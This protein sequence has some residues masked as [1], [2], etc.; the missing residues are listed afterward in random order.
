MNIK[1]ELLKE[2]SKQQALK[3][4]DYASASSKNFNQ[5]MQCF[6]SD[7]NLVAQ[8]AAWSVSWAAKTNPKLIQP[9]IKI[10]L[11]CLKERMYTMQ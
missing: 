4:A 7:E 5:V 2:H 9:Y 6:L 3:I 11:P 1:E 10:W 8:R